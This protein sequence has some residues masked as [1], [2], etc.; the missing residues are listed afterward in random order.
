[1]KVLNEILI[2]KNIKYFTDGDH[3]LSGS[4]GLVVV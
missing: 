1:M 4:G 3:E 2:D